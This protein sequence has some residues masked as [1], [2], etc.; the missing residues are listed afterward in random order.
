MSSFALTVG[1]H[2]YGPN[3]EFVQNF[4]FIMGVLL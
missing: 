1:G 4:S 2:T 3:L